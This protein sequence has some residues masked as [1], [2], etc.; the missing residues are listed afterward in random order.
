MMPAARPGQGRASSMKGGIDMRIDRLESTRPPRIR[1]GK[2][3]P[4]LRLWMPV[5][6]SWIGSGDDR[7]WA[8]ADRIDDEM[9]TWL[10]GLGA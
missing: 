7:L 6:D 10:D 5:T 3:R 9:P 1:R 2:S 8:A 4:A